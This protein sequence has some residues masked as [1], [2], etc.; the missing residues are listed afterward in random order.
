MLG[1]GNPHVHLLFIWIELSI[2]SAVSLLQFHIPIAVTLASQVS[3]SE[4]YPIVQV[5]GAL[6]SLTTARIL[7]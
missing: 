1:D 6:I 2:H 4:K 5:G 3:V 7:W